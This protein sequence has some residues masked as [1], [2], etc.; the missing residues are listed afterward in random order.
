RLVNDIAAI[1]PAAR[2]PACADDPSAVEIRRSAH[3]SLDRVTRAI[4]TLRFNTAVAF[5]H[6]QVSR[7]EILL[8]DAD[9]GTPAVHA[10]LREAGEILVQVVAP[11]MPH[12]AEQCWAALGHTTLVAE[13]RWRVAEPPLVVGEA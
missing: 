2:D 13:T 12:L 5:I 3:Q 11:L 7:L 1:A 8:R 9:S 10:A 6:T 4:E